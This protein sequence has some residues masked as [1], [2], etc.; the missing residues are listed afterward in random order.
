[1]LSVFGLLVFNLAF[2]AGCGGEGGT[3][4]DGGRSDAS[5]DAGAGAG[6]RLSIAGLPLVTVQVGTSANLEVSLLQENVGAVAGETI[7]FEIVGNASDSSLG[8]AVTAT[9]VTD[10]QGTASITL[11]AGNT[12]TTFQV[13]ASAPG[14]NRVAFGVQVIQLQQIIQIAQTPSVRVQV[15]GT[16][17]NVD[18]SAFTKVI[19][20]VRITDQFGSAM[21]GLTVYY[22]FQ[23][24]AK[25]AAFEA[26]A[27]TATTGTG[28]EAE[29]NLETGI[30]LRDV[31][32]VTARSDASGTASWTVNL[33]DAG[34][35]LCTIDT[36]CPQGQI[37]D[38]N[39]L[40]AGAPGCDE[41][42]GISCPTGYKCLVNN[43][44]QPVFSTTCTLDE[45]CGNGFHCDLASG[46]CT[47]D[48]PSCDVSNPCPTG[49]TCNGGACEPDP[50][51][52][53]PDISG[54]WYTSHTF[55]IGNAIPFLSDVAG[56]IRT[57]DRLFL[58]DLGLPGF[59]ENALRSIVAKYVPSWVPKLVHVLDV[60]A[61]VMQ[62]LRARG[63]ATINQTG[64]AWTGTEVWESFIFYDLTKCGAHP[65]AGAT[66][67]CAR[68]DL[69]VSSPTFPADLGLTVKPFSG[70]V[71]SDT[72]IVNPR[73]VDM[74]VAKLVGW[75][76]DKL[77]DL[78]TPY[79]TLAEALVAVINCHSIGVWVGD[80]SWGLVSAG[81]AENL[82]KSG[83]SKGA[84]A[85]TNALYNFAF[86]VG[87]LTFN[88][89]ASI[90]SIR[91]GKAQ[92]LGT[93][94]F[95][96]TNDGSYIGD[97]LTNA[98]HSITGTWRASRKKIH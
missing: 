50:G 93:A 26:G 87:V 53:P 7:S 37:C 66:P 74:R 69:F 25:S 61:T 49:F 32:I 42:K 34:L 28:G 65:G 81:S 96:E 82:C 12:Q 60:I 94:T 71:S 55:N 9:A 58:G 64:N 47:A 29:L 76:V 59:V 6:R 68:V 52:P 51:G 62:N 84:T 1:L 31:F 44:C 33:Q 78:Y 21:E 72:V 48:Q 24:A 91:S 56:P 85:V 97:F 39:G 5:T 83:V 18:I 38:T 11:D 77:V 3:G 27:T 13:A 30:D 98:L 23:S 41:A 79:K 19:L 57:I 90:S 46:A 43:E 2:S 35:K 40:C 75:L 10:A 80:N 20:R 4:L 92:E 15:N 86:S 16:Q 45:Q 67:S 8:G 17:A 95:E 22:A 89:E 63:Y 36:D 88:G 73:E 54:P 14:A 70:T